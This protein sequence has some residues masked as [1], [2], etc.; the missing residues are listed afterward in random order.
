MTEVR[1]HGCYISASMTVRKTIVA[2]IAAVVLAAGSGVG[3]AFAVR[4]HKHHNS[5]GASSSTSTIKN[6]GNGGAGGNSGAAGAGG[7]AFN[8]F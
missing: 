2:A 6:S 4:P 1:E 5:S 7:A 3:T 8:S